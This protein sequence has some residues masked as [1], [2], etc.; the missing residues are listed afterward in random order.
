MSPIQALVTF[1]ALDKITEGNPIK[2]VL[3]QREFYLHDNVLR[4]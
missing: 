2:G 4:V 3:F 1:I